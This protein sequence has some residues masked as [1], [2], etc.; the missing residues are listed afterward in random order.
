[1]P[2]PYWN[3]LTAPGR[4]PVTPDYLKPPP[5]RVS[6]TLS[7]DLRKVQEQALLFETLVKSNK[8]EEAFKVLRTILSADLISID[9]QSLLSGAGLG[10]AVSHHGNSHF[11]QTQFIVRDLRD[12]AGSSNYKFSLAV[13]NQ[14]LEAEKKRFGNSDL[15]VAATLISIGDSYFSVSNFREAL[16]PYRQSLNIQKLYMTEECAITNLGEKFFQCLINNR[17]NKEASRLRA[18]QKE[19]LAATTAKSSFTDLDSLDLTPQSK[20]GKALVLYKQISTIRPYGYE[21]EDYLQH[22]VSCSRLLKKNDLLCK[23]TPLLIEVMERRGNRDDSEFKKYREVLIQANLNKGDL[24]S[25]RFWV[26]KTNEGETHRLS[27]QE[28]IDF[29]NLEF[30]V[31]RNKKAERYLEQAEQAVPDDFNSLRN[32]K[33]IE[34]AWKLLNRQDRVEKIQKRIAPLEKNYPHLNPWSGTYMSKDQRFQEAQQQADVKLKQVK[35]LLRRNAKGATDNFFEDMSLLLQMQSPQNKLELKLKILQLAKSLFMARRIEE[36][37]KIAFVVGGHP[38]YDSEPLKLSQ[39]ELEIADLLLSLNLEPSKQTGTYDYQLFANDATLFCGESQNPSLSELQAE[40]RYRIKKIMMVNYY[41]VHMKPYAGMTWPS[42]E[43]PQTYA[44][45]RDMIAGLS[46]YQNFDFN[47]DEENEKLYKSCLKPGNPAVLKPKQTFKPGI[48][49]P[50]NAQ[51][52]DSQIEKLTLS[53]G[54]FVV[55]T[56]SIDSLLISA[57]GTVRLFLTEEST[58]DG[59]IFV[60]R[61]NGRM[62]AKPINTMLEI[63]YEGQGTIRIEDNC[64][65]GGTIYAPNAR[66]EIGKDFKLKGSIA[67]RDIWLESPYSKF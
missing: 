29:A 67:A 38:S 48:S 66:V 32:L 43:S 59:P 22:I 12:V 9:G 37:K 1:M 24:Y 5:R 30:K 46:M 57:P 31:N 10:R 64:I 16:V 62:N 2:P 36:G 42:V 56:A 55:K 63:W 19:R 15:R 44:L 50:L 47:T 61:K 33:Q 35:E 27:P 49:P 21:S 23:Y 52:L 18:L 39:S 17:E 54:S 14:I 25:A 20:L 60:V 26:D 45:D 13:N 4:N 65:L 3:P 6:G 11:R 8:L 58:L 53:P 41:R 51:K 7:P 40:I 34:N 28:L